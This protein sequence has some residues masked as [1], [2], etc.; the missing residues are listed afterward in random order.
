MHRHGIGR[1]SIAHKKAHHAL[2]MVGFL[3]NDG[4]TKAPA[5][6][7]G[8]GLVRCWLRG[9]TAFD[10]GTLACAAGLGHGLVFMRLIA[11]YRRV[12]FPCEL[13]V[14]FK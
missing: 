1:F 6:D 8:G 9:V 2:G 3:V 12:L 4:H 11:V 13:H 14:L 5:V 7:H 10:V